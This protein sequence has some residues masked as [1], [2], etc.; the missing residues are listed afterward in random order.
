MEDNRARGDG[1]LSAF[2][3]SEKRPKVA[4]AAKSRLMAS[5]LHKSGR[6]TVYTQA[7]GAMLDICLNMYKIFVTTWCVMRDLLVVWGKTETIISSSPTDYKNPNLCRIR[8]GGFWCLS[9]WSSNQCPAWS[10][11]PYVR[12]SLTSPGRIC[13]FAQAYATMIILWFLATQY[14]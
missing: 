9:R 2:V 7:K 1:H 6:W 8:K 14:F 12:W 11:T 10:A 4:K 13:P 5:L 3:F